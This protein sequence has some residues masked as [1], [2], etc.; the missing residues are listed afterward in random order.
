MRDLSVERAECRMLIK[1]N[2]KKSELSKG[3]LVESFQW[4]CSVQINNTLRCV[5][6]SHIS[7]K[8]PIKDKTEKQQLIENEVESTEWRQSSEVNKW[9]VLYNSDCISH[10]HSSQPKTQKKRQS[11]PRGLLHFTQTFR[12]GKK[13]VKRNLRETLDPGKR[14]KVTIPVDM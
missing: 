12:G 11:Q 8:S 10:T 4:E 13:E 6:Y 7:M 2:T 5:N 9:R 3:N 14:I 1:Q